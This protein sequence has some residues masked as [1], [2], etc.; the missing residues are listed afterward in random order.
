MSGWRT[1][2]NETKTYRTKLTGTPEQWAKKMADIK[3]RNHEILQEGKDPYT[4][5]LMDAGKVSN[6]WAVCKIPS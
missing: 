6:Y 4:G 2:K 3:A 1:I 5:D